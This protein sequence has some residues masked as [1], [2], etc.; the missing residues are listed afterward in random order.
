MA[1]VIAG[2][3]LAV[4]FLP[5]CLALLLQIPHVQTLAADLATRLASEKLG[6]RVEIDRLRVG[7]FNRVVVDGFYVEDFE[8]DTLLYAAHAEVSVARLGLLNE[9]ILFGDA[10]LRD[11]KFHLRETPRGEMNVKE[12][13]DRMRPAQRKEKKS[14]FQLRFKRL[15]VEG[16]EFWLKRNEPP[17]YDYGIDWA[18]MRLKDLWGHLSDFT[19]L[20][21]EISGVINH[22][23]GSEQSGFRL[24]N[25]SGGLL[26]HDGR[27][28]MNTVDIETEQSHIRMPSFS[29]S[30][31]GWADYKYF[32]DYVVIEAQ[33][34]DSSLTTD[35]IAYFAPTLRDWH[36][37]AE[38]IDLEVS[39]TVNHLKTQI[40][41]LQTM[42][43]TSLMADLQMQGLPR[44]DRT[45]FDLKLHSLVTCID[46]ASQLCSAI[47]RQ[48]LSPSLV[49]MLSEMGKTNLSGRFV[50]KI[51]D[52]SAQLLA[53]TEIGTLQAEADLVQRRGRYELAAAA[54]TRG[55]RAGRLLS[56]ADLGEV[57]LQTSAMGTISRM[58]PDLQ[59]DA[60]ISKLYFK[61]VAYDSL[62]MEAFLKEKLYTATLCSKNEALDLTLDASADLSGVRS[63]YRA[64]L[65][66]RRANLTA[67]RL[68]QR[69][70]ISNLS[71][72]LSG[73]LYAS[74]LE[75]LCGEL[76]IR[77]ARYQYND[78]LV[79]APELRLEALNLDNRHELYLISP[80]TDVQIT[81]SRTYL[82]AFSMLKNSLAHYLPNLYTLSVADQIK[83]P[84][85]SAEDYTA[86]EV[87]VKELSP[88][89]QAIVPGLEVAD[90]TQLQL[91]HQP[92]Q[93][94]LAL[95]LH[96][97][98]LE[99]ENLLALDLNLKAQNEAD[100][101]L[102][103]ASVGE[104]LMGKM[105]L[106][107]ISLKGGAR[108][109]HFHL[110]GAFSDSLRMKAH[111]N[112]AGSVERNTE[113]FRR[114]TLRVN[115]SNFS[116]DG[117][118][119]AIEAPL[120]ELD[121]T[122]I[123]VNRFLIHNS[124][125][126]L[127]LDGI[128]SRSREDSIRLTL[129]NFDLSPLTSFASSLGFRIKGVSNGFATAKSA[130]HES[131]ITADIRIDSMAINER[132]RIA[133]LQLIS[134]WDFEKNRA[135][136]FIINRSLCD[137]VIR[138]YYIPT[139]RRYAAH[140]MVDSLPMSLLDPMLQGVISQTE[141]FTQADLTISGMGR[142]ANLQGTLHARDL[143]TCID[144][145]QVTY[146]VPEA[147]VKVEENRFTAE[148][149][150]LFDLEGN[151]GDLNFMLDLNHLSNIA[152]RLNV[153][154]RKMLVLNTTNKD[155]D[156]FYGHIYASGQALIRGDKMGVR[157]NVNASTEDNSSFSMPLSGSTNVSKADFVTFLSA[158][159]P[160]TTNYL[161]RRRMMFE[162]RNRQKSKSGGNMDINLSLNVHP[163]VDFQLVIDPQAGDQISG[164]GEGLLN[165]RVNPRDNIF[166]MLG[167][168]VIQE[169][170]YLFTLQ[171][172]I[173]KKFVIEDGSSIQWTGEPMDAILDI[174]AI[175]KRK[176]SLQPILGASMSADRNANTR[177]VPVECVIHL[178]DR[179]SDPS[180]EF[181]IR[182]PQADSET[183]T[184]VANILNTEATIARQFIYLLAFGSFYPENATASNDNIGAVASAT[185]GFEFLSNQMG[186]LLS[187]EDYDI[188]LRYRPETEMTDEEVDFGFATNLIDNRLLI[189][190]E[191]NYIIDNKQATTNR[192]SNFM[193]EAYITFM[194]D[195]AGN[196]KLRGFT[197][198]IDRFDETQGLQET[199]LGIYYKED[200]DNFRDWREQLKARFS[201][202][203]RRMRRAERAA[204]RAQRKGS[205]GE[206]TWEVE[207]EIPTA[208]GSKEEKVPVEVRE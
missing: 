110:S 96:S 199:G 74:S 191:G 156:L 117:K 80:F 72:Q 113:G 11:A 171:N 109:S 27:I 203:Q 112:M 30:G 36:L 79:V 134:R 15:S 150:P 179:L 101:L 182:V 97:D 38:A 197:Q 189:E 46:E 102:L 32:V 120:M 204:R 147:I 169:G 168:Y 16:V 77:N 56:V 128:A 65:D 136:L 4:I 62:R 116:I 31:D 21:G 126:E 157:M 86:I 144:Y 143:S 52:F 162:R 118:Q 186:N 181:S 166:E 124:S 68:N 84:H 200:F 13:V 60:E 88:L 185:T 58:G 129:H 64:D 148:G 145:T 100:S 195:R 115:D 90:N 125:E 132:V 19:I 3:L 26:V 28:A 104:L 1:K 5:F 41:S 133:P 25:L 208:R 192:M 149:V 12:V 55:F 164:K 141:G 202:E 155:N 39:G 8:R 194:I 153:A 206:T 66:L 18:D 175:Y 139:E 187:G 20:G 71:L 105:K 59:I 6:V 63:R 196:L 83:D 111:L 70:S 106:N 49:K 37:A 107:Q 201:G 73:D 67:M 50:G 29:L 207:E 42:D 161:V 91:L 146:R 127:L 173:N 34:E 7:F 48:D 82:E 23:A 40:Y 75:N 103:D 61:E 85:S 99:R 163:N 198:T 98:F 17:R 51:S 167:D 10:L 159:L 35:D 114:L 44:V 123:Y 24:N 174:N 137:T 140:L 54:S 89:S 193:G 2:G 172:V 152:Y 205:E 165:I 81:S 22:L 78:S 57:N 87:R 158:D 142:K 33:V 160:D 184:A 180:K 53:A 121:S 135:G 177:L 138:G 188:V 69:D 176:T 45:R 170:S 95:D 190:V 47:L 76:L 94:K 130:L 93:G 9:G 183:Q 92:S 43:A 14:P 108:A 154:P 131:E 119:W 151:Q 122:R 178:G